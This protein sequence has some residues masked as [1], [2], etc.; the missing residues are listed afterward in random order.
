MQIFLLEGKICIMAQ[1]V[2]T[3]EQVGG[4]VD[5]LSRKV[6]KEGGYVVFVRTGKPESVLL[7]AE[8]FESL[9]ETVEVLK[10]SPELPV[11]F[12]KVKEA[13]KRGK[14]RFWKGLDEVIE[15]YGVS[16]KT[17]SSRRKGA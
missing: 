14:S 13:I 7:S 15:E 17:H 8:E 4:E 5:K 3:T 6:R 11:E 10:E 16:N 2:I 1:F 9:K 12:K